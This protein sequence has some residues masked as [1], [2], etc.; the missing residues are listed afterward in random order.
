MDFLFNFNENRLEKILIS[1]VGTL[2]FVYLE[3]DLF[4]S[5]IFIMIE[6]TDELYTR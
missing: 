1:A 5:R 6:N 2:L 4:G 3:A